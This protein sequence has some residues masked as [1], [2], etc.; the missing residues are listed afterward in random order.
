MGGADVAT[1]AAVGGTLRETPRASGK[2]VDRVYTAP[3]GTRMRSWAE[4]ERWLAANQGAC[5]PLRRCA[6]LRASARGGGGA[7]GRGCGG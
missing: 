3:D 1:W 2:A 4:C 7:R 5:A 6:R